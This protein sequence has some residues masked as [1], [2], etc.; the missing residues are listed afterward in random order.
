MSLRTT[1]YRIL[2][3]DIDSMGYL[4]YGRYLALFE[5]GRVE[6]MRA[7]GLR[8]RDMETRMGL[9][10]PVTAASCRYRAPLHYDDLAWIR[11]WIAAWSATTVRFAHEVR[12]EEDGPLCATGEVE[13]GCVDA[14]TRR[15]A[16][17]PEALQ[18]IREVRAPGA[19]GRRRL[20]PPA[21]GDDHGSPVP[22]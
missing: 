19:R 1:T 13:L 6:W 10:L 5:L 15:P 16:R 21:G 4:Y 14:R 18:G 12:A 7:E 2:Y 17:L 20:A 3:R 11:T 9:M 8:Y 22:D